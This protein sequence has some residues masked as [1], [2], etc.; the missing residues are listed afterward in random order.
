MR[1]IGQILACPKCG[2]MVQIAPPTGWTPPSAETLAARAGDSGASTGSTIQFKTPVSSAEALAAAAAK[3]REAAA[4]AAMAAAVAASTSGALGNAG[5]ASGA[6]PAESPD[7]SEMMDPMAAV[8]TA[9]GPAASVGDA[10][11]PVGGARAAFVRHAWDGVLSRASGVGRSMAQ[12]W[13]YW[14]CGPIAAVAL[15]LV[16]WIFYQST[17]PKTQFAAVA[18]T[19]K[20][21]GATEATP[22][23]PIGQQP[24]DVNPA[25]PSAAAPALE[26]PQVVAPTEPAVAQNRAVE[27]PAQPSAPTPAVDARENAAPV[28]TDPPMPV[29]PLPNA[30]SKAGVATPNGAQPN[31]AMPAGAN[32]P[33]GPMAKP[34]ENATAA[35]GAASIPNGTGVKEIAP[36]AA[37]PK[38][39]NPDGETDEDD[40]EAAQPTVSSPIDVAARLEDPLETI[41][42]RR[43][44]L[45]DFCDFL[46]NFSTIPI[47]LDVDAMATVGVA[48]DEPLLGI[49]K[50]HTTV[51]E[52]LSSVLA[53]HRLI[54]EIQGQQLLV[55]A[56][57]VPPVVGK[58]DVSEL[59]KADKGAAAQLPALVARFVSP[60]SWEATGGKGKI[61]LSDDGKLIVE[62]SPAVQR[63]VCTFI[64]RLRVARGFTPKTAP[65]NSDLV[66][67]TKY[68]RVKERLQKSP[69]TATYGIET[70]LCEVLDWLGRA[71]GTRILIDGVS[72][73]QVERTARSPVTLIA[74]KQ[75]L[76]EA[77]TSLLDPLDLTFRVIDEKTLQVYAKKPLG[78]RYEFEIHPVR[79]LVDGATKPDKILSVIH[80]K[81]DPKSWSEAGGPGVIEYDAASKSLLVLQSAT[82]Q[83]RLEKMLDKSR[84][85]AAARKNP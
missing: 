34:E 6:A 69:I 62:H 59:L 24:A 71:T 3:R 40:P 25:D 30:P 47:T 27:N 48:P 65:A 16:G 50:S 20:A 26:D 72:L 81:I 31:V 32:I 80:E 76:D 36:R 13:I 17:T 84:A 14:L 46:S 60:N 70:P 42:F 53:E 54:Y 61:S 39:E 33:A 35:N 64:E 10:A 51:G 58:Y 15:V 5:V 22:A 19:D 79:E 85:G 83:I 41:E 56:A 67:K 9:N 82:A 73:T 4:A 68:G 7:F 63:R 75:P 43:I 74:D 44:L 49:R 11:T 21:Q 18:P 23:A 55:T 78:E 29:D 37:N 1:A 77:L 52:L 2:G 12:N 66:L 57:I 45:V 38:A 8:P 28:D